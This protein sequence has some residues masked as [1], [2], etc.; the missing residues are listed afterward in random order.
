M[1]GTKREVIKSILEMEPSLTA[2]EVRFAIHV[3]DD[4]LPNNTERQ[5]ENDRRR[6]TEEDMREAFRWLV[7][8]QLHVKRL[9]VL[10][11]QIQNTIINKI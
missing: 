2:A 4:T 3:Y 11:G 9:R 8:E 1:S 7:K 6:P 10:E 5:V